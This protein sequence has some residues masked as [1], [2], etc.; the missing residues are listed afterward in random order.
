MQGPQ[1][2]AAPGGD[3]DFDGVDASHG[4]YDDVEE[5]AHADVISSYVDILWADD[6]EPIEVQIYLYNLQC[7]I[8]FLIYTHMNHNTSQIF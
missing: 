2:E 3:G 7:N 1:S 6:D 8:K 4:G 5:A